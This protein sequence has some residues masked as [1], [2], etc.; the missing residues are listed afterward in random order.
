MRCFYITGEVE[1]QEACGC[2][3]CDLEIDSIDTKIN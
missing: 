3:E 2:G 1:S